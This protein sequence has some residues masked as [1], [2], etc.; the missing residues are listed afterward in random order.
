MF[1]IEYESYLVVTRFAYVYHSQITVLANK[2]SEKPT[3]Q[4]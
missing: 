2:I 3:C 1:V 4:K